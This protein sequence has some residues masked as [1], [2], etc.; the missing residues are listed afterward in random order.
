MNEIKNKWRELTT[1]KDEFLHILRILNHYYE[2]RGENRSERFIFRET[3][4]RTD[5]GDIQIYFS[6]IGEYEYQV[7]CAIPKSAKIESW[8]HIDGIA[9]ERMKMREVGNLEHPVFS[10]VCLGDL[11]QIAVETENPVL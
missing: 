1:K 4:V 11:F 2:M 8:I 10:L 9:E 5:P 6:K 7:A 3:L